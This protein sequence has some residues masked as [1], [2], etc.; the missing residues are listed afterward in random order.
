MG[1]ID[2]TDPA[3]YFLPPVSQYYNRFYMP[4]FIDA[5]G[6]P[7]QKAA[8]MVILTRTIRESN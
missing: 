2:P 6:E 8:V 4:S 1:L 5:D 3:L 7:Y